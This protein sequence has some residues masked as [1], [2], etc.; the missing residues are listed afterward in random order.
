MPFF[1]EFTPH[2]SDFSKAIQW[3]LNKKSDVFKVSPYGDT[4]AMQQIQKKQFDEVLSALEK[5]T[6][7]PEKDYCRFTF[8]QM[9]LLCGASQEQLAKFAF[10]DAKFG[11]N[12]ETRTANGAQQSFMMAANQ[13]NLE[14]LQ[15]FLT[16]IQSHCKWQSITGY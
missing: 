9:A 2:P 8:T 4:P 13:V 16:P 6:I 1:K 15:S 3:L 14:A 5:G 7:N 11:N 10:Y 12:S